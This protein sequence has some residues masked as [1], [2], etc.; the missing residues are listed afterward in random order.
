MR[1]YIGYVGGPS[2]LTDI[3][4]KLDA[5]DYINFDKQTQMIYPKDI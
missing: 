4:R 1:T 2:D 5:S 3:I